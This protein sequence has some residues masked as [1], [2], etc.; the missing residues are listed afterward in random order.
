MNSTRFSFD[1]IGTTWVIDVDARLTPPEK[2]KIQTQVMRII[3]QF[4]IT[5]SRFREDSLINH[6][7][8]EAGVYSFPPNA[9][10]LFDFYKTMYDLTN[11]VFTPLVGNT[12]SDAGY[13]LAYTLSQKK[14]LV[15]PPTWE[16]VMEYHSGKLNVTHPSILD[17]G[18]AGKGYLIDLVGDLLKKLKYSIGIIDAGHDIVSFGTE[19]PIRVGLEHPT[20]T[21]QVIGVAE[22]HNRSI[23]ASAG[24]RRKW[25]SFHHIINPLTLTSPHEILA[26]WAVAENGLIADGISTALFLVD[27]QLLLQ[28]YEFEYVIVYKDLSAKKSKSFPGELFMK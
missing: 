17:F 16:S 7:S 18:A 3:E 1:A 8:Q 13:D 25:G 15:R 9:D 6:I 23:C 11:G 5:Y 21:T 2:E 10:S 26:T 19:K 20:D 24:N 12:L 14:K 27:P 4:D 28:K 22:I